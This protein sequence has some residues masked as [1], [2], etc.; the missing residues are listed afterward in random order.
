MVLILFIL[1]FLF[2]AFNAPIS[3]SLGA[4]SAITAYLKGGAS[5]II[6]PQKIFTSLDSFPPPRHP[7]LHPG[8]VLP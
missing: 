3:F 1:F 8:R 7:S 5:L 2:M 6:L 4:A